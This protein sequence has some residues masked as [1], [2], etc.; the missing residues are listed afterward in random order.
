MDLEPDP[1]GCRFDALSIKGQDGHQLLQ[2]TC[3]S[4]IPFPT[5]VNDSRVIINFKSDEAE[6]KTGF[7]LNWRAI[8]PPRDEFDCN[9]ERGYCQGR[10][11]QCSSSENSFKS[12]Q[13][14]HYFCSKGH[15][16]K[17]SKLRGVGM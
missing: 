15:M 3:G 5:V 10:G 7:A 1:A 6:Q 4:K 17:I 11:Q 12:V 9:F 2:R 8:E 14:H 16:N 13:D